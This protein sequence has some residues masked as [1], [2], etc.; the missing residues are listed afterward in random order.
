MRQLVYNISQ[1]S[2]YP[3]HL[4]QQS[5]QVWRRS[6]LVGWWGKDNRKWDSKAHG[7]IPWTNIK[8]A[9]YFHVKFLV[10]G[11]GCVRHTTKFQRTSMYLG[12][13]WNPLLLPCVWGKAL[14]NISGP[15]STW[16]YAFWSI[17]SHKYRCKQVLKRFELVYCSTTSDFFHSVDSLSCQTKQI[18]NQRTSLIIMNFIN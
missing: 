14:W 3:H 15:V 8:Q 16:Y 6:R 2:K 13:K 5:E 7:K 10:V 9:Y 12:Q 4:I 11:P 1:R 18:D 17:R